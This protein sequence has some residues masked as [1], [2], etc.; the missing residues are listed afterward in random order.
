MQVQNLIF[1][2][3]KINLKSITMYTSVTHTLKYINLFD[4]KY[5]LL[6]MTTH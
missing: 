4:T 3:I 5:S 2:T 6:G 1:T